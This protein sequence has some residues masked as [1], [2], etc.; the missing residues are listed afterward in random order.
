MISFQEGWSGVG[1][2]IDFFIAGFFVVA[3]AL[4]EVAFLVAPSFAVRDDLERAGD[5]FPS[6]AASG[7]GEARG[8]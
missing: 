1:L 8:D 6:A 2:E 7:A 4:A 3:E 5:F